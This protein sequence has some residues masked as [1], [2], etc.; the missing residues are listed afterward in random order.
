MKN[1]SNKHVAVD[2]RS[3]KRMAAGCWAALF[4]LNQEA[5]GSW[6]SRSGGQKGKSK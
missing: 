1:V 5:S 4:F 3:E 6:P 2:G